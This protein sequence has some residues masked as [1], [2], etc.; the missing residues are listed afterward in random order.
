MKPGISPEL[1][2]IISACFSGQTTEK[3]NQDL[4]SE[5]IARILVG[6]R[7][8][9]YAFGR[10]KPDSLNDQVK[11]KL[12]NMC[13]TNTFSTLLQASETLK[14]YRLASD[15]GIP[16]HFYKGVA[17][18][19]W[20]FNDVN[21][22]AP[23]DIDLFVAR[24]HLILLIEALKK[25]GYAIHPFHDTLLHASEPTSSDFLNSDYHIPLSGK[26][27]SGFTNS[28][29]ELHWK[30]AYPRLCF[31]FGP[32]DFDKYGVQMEFLHHQIPVF[33]T[34][35][36]FLMMIVNHGGKEDWNRLKYVIDLKAYMDR[37]GLHTDWALVDRI[38]TAKGVKKL[39]VRG[40][41]ILQELGYEWKPEFPEASQNVGIENL[42][43]T[44][45]RLQPLPGNTSWLY[46]KHSVTKRDASHRFKILKAHLRF[47][48]HFRLHSQ[49]LKWYKEHAD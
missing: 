15:L 32:A 17:W 49:K 6:N 34:E 14:I 8:L 4:D 38:A 35:Y 48:S 47:I 30:I 7:I 26:D 29:V 21:M 3:S 40:L 33:S 36:Q 10:I 20:L 44:W 1:D 24:E 16:V 11:E 12:E 25:N 19:Q 9:N 42:R 28:V 39:V 5:E 22:R 45:F 37:Y 18:S 2:Y 41:G 31:D 13:R 43:N 46:F 27:K 23:G